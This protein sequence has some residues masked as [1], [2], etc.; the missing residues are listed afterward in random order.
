MATTR[1]YNELFW[2][3]AYFEER[4]THYTFSKSVFFFWHIIRPLKMASFKSNF[5]FSSNFPEIFPTTNI[6]VNIPS[7]KSPAG[8]YANGTLTITIAVPTWWTWVSRWVPSPWICPSTRRSCCISVLPSTGAGDREARGSAVPPA[9]PC[10]CH[11]RHG[12]HRTPWSWPIF[13]DRSPCPPRCT[14]PAPQAACAP[15]VVPFNNLFGAVTF[16]QSLVRVVDG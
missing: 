2:S 1:M 4:C 9:C 10:A 8:K 13:P 5:D 7:Y 3:M 12:R 11:R 16:F 15:G 14:A 6:V